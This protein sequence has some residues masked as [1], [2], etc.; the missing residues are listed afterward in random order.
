MRTSHGILA[1]GAAALVAAACVE[2][3]AGDDALSDSVLGGA[4]VDAPAGDGDLTSSFVGGSTADAPGQSADFHGG[5]AGRRMGP[6]RASGRLHDH[7]LGG[8]GFGPGGRSGRFARAF[9]C[10]GTFDPVSGRVSCAP[11]SLRNG[12]TV[13]RSASYADASG[14]LQQA[15]DSLTT[16]TV[17]VRATVSGAITSTAPDSLFSRRCRRG[18]RVAMEVAAHRGPGGPEGL[19]DQHR[20]G[21]TGRLLG[22]TAR[23]LSATI[24]VSNGSDRTVSGLAQGATHRTVRGISGGTVTTTGRST[25]GR[26]TA[27]RTTADTM[28]G[29]VIPVSTTGAAYPTAGTVTRTMTTTLK[30]EGERAVRR[31][32]REVVTYDGTATA[33]VMIT[34]NDTTRS[35]TRALP[36]GPLDCG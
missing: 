5:N 30:Y 2:P 15:Y 33:K 17:N 9:A 29:V 20:P 27:T 1:A 13:L 16:N 24:A 10:D 28:T 7:F 11:K 19:G 35:C 8:I 34:E 18:N 36:R 31:S 14:A 21:C 12:L 26:F 32:R 4:F 3:A 6:E 22:D 23:L 25:R